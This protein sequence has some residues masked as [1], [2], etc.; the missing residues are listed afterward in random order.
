MEE[1]F[2]CTALVIL[3]M[4]SPPASRARFSLEAASDSLL[5]AASLFSPV[6]VSGLFAMS[7][8]CAARVRASMLPLTSGNDREVVA[9]WKEHFVKVV[10]QETATK[11]EG[12]REMNTKQKGH[13]MSVL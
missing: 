8:S 10:K 7:S 1:G 9:I 6:R 2:V 13:Q 12:I 11:D 3:W 5:R 4:V